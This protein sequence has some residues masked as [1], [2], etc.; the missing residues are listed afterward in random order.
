MKSKKILSALVATA[1]VSGA[2][3]A[4]A[5]VSVNAT[6]P[7]SVVRGTVTL[8]KAV[9]ESNIGEEFTVKVD[10]TQ[11]TGIVYAQLY[12]AYN[13]DVV[14]LVK[15]E[16][17]G[18][19]LDQPLLQ[20]LNILR[21]ANLEKG[22]GP[23]ANPFTFNLSR[24]DS[25]NDI[26]TLGSL[27][28]V[29]FKVIAPGN[30]NITFSE[31]PKFLMNDPASPQTLDIETIE[32]EFVDAPLAGEPS[33]TT[34]ETT[35]G[36]TVSTATTPTQAPGSSDTTSGTTATTAPGGTTT[37]APGSPNTGVSMLA[38]LPAAIAAGALVVVARKRK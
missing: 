5:P 24:V 29:K 33:G 11:N 22:Y 34:S 23:W 20:D 17:E 6:G 13:A 36:T 12:F 7:G 21:G 25:N 15:E 8:P 28:S 10:L 30:T 19:V 27:V 32:F 37:R 35:S 14:E 2:A 1:L 3:V 26:K 16:D 38:L 9:T 4:V 18:E 31:Q